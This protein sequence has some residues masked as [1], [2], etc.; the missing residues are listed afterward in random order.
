LRSE[1]QKV[2]YGYRPVSAD[3]LP[4]IGRS[5]RLQNLIIATGHQMIGVS[6]GPATGL[7]VSEIVQGKRTTVPVELFAPERHG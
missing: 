4:Y 5:K 7:L 1:E 2:W 6:L 3:G